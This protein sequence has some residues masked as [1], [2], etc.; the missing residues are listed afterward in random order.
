L[1]K[2][3]IINNIKYFIV[4]IVALKLLTI[5]TG[6]VKY[7]K[8][9]FLHTFG[10]KI[11][12]IIIFTGFCLFILLENIVIINIGI[13]F[14]IISSFEELLITIIGK[15]HNE[16]IKGIWELKVMGHSV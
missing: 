10:N 4:L 3:Y 7:K 6:Y 9:C 16:N 13:L 12:G 2:F 15:E 8:L 11:S 14:S 1:F 5:I